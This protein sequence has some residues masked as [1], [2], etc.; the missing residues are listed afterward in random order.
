MLE[1]VG[2]GRIKYRDPKT[3]KKAMQLYKRFRSDPSYDYYGVQAEDQ[4]R[5]LE[6]EFPQLTEDELLMENMREK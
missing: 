3:Q 5:R 2:Q 4:Q 6:Q 1:S